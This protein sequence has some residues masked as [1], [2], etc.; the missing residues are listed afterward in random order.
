MSGCRCSIVPPHLL[1]RIVRTGTAQDRESALN[2]LAIDHSVRTLRVENSSLRGA[3]ARRLTRTHGV[4]GAPV[5]VIYDAEH[6]TDVRAT[7]VRR[8]AGDP[9]VGDGAVNQ[10]YDGLGRTYGLYWDVYHR[11]SID[12]AGLPLLGEVH[13]GV[14]YDNAF[15]HGERMTVG[16]GA[17]RLF[18]C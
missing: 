17:G 16:D 14:D 15:W 13:F 7:R 6:Q 11:D 18:N 1:E 9:P 2:T 12:D 10:A 3:A 8:S 5:R 4:G